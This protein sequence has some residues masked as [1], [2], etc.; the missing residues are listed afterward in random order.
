[1]RRSELIFNATLVPVDYLMIVAAGLA[2]YWLRFTALGEEMPI[3]YQ[4][5]S[6][7]FF[8]VV[9]AIA[10]IWLVIFALA[11]LYNIKIYQRL[12]DE[13]G[14][15]FLACSAGMMLIVFIIFIR[16]EFFSSRFIILS[17]WVLAIIFVSLARIFLR[18]FR[19]FCF[20]KGIGRHRA[21]I[22]GNSPLTDNI[23]KALSD[24]P[25]SGYK[26]IDWIKDPEMID[27]LR[28]QKIID[29]GSIDELIQTDPNLAK[30]KTMPLV[31]FCDEH[32]ITFRYAADLFD[33]LATNVEVATIAG[34][35]II[36]IKRT[37]L[38]GWGKIVKRVF[39]IL[40]AAI[41]LIILSPL[42][43]VLA[44]LIKLNSKGPAIVSLDRIGGRG[45]PFKLFKFRSM[46]AN[47][48]QMKKNL[49]D[50]NEI[51]RECIEPNR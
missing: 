30:E 25:A 35:P 34:I 14:R 31:D 44:I 29:S 46:I 17:G 1:M 21:L 7:N 51:H 43:I 13:L 9:L 40:V 20:R 47:A 36:E 2:A 11:A 39:D 15:V 24:N 45:K 26:I 38:D 5:P 18:G 32:H 28:L 49:V 37:S 6:K 23:I 33:A 50:Y 16:R 19:R 4:V 27:S 3:I 42:F 22:V 8:F 41:S 48:H 12:T 10:L